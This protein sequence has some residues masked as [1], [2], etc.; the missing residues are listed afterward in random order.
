[1]A[2]P[3]AHM[4]PP[5]RR[6]LNAVPQTAVAEQTPEDPLRLGRGMR[7]RLRAAVLTLLA[8]P[9]LVG[10]KDAARL[11]AVVLFAKA[12]APQGRADDNTTSTWGP[13]LGRW[14]GM[15][16]STIHH[17]VL[18][19]LRESGALRTRVVTDTKGHPTGLDC[20]VMPLWKARRAG[21][22]HPLALSKVELATLLRLLEALFGPGWEPKGKEPVPPGLLARRGRTGKG[23]ATDRLA[24]LLMVL[25]TSASGWL[26]LRGGSVVTREG[27]GA[28][29]VARLLACSP[30]GARKV[31][32]RLTTAGVVG[33]ERKATGTRMNGRGRISVL[34]VAQAYGRT[35]MP[36]G[37]ERA[38]GSRPVFRTVLMLQSEIMIG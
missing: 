11:A 21:V 35:L 15:T 3:V 10:V 20:L 36:V 12:R 8:D 33:R 30:A 7:L 38:L 22:T 16:E 19:A 37:G 23:A 4:S 31:L 32:A 17:A 24:L 27:R 5:R 14:L 9:S 13:E 2:A 28:A 1:M 29:T 34:P 18:P 25:H 26:Q 6:G